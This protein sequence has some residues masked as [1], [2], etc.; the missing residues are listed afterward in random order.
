[1]KPKVLGILTLVVVLC[2]MTA[3]VPLRAQYGRDCG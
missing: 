3:V 1:M 2:A